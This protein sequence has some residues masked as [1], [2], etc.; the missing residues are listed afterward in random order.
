MAD[1]SVRVAGLEQLEAAFKKAPKLVLQRTDKALSDSGHDI[2]RSVYNEIN[3]KHIN[4]TGQMGQNVDSR[5][6]GALKYAVIV[7]KNY[8]AGVEE[9]TK[10]HGVPQKALERYVGVKFGLPKNKQYIVARAIKRRIQR[11]G[12]K[13]HP[14]FKPGIQRVLDK[15][16][17]NFNSIWKDLI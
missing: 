16:Q 2:V 6:L 13:A 11:Q 17:D 1:F 10:P 5:K 8:A 15:V 7:N 9:G 3:D 14:F 4:Y 12:T